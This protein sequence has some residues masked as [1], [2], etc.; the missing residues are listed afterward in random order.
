MLL[1][2]KF[3]ALKWFIWRLKSCHI[4]ISR[5]F[6]SIIKSRLLIKRFSLWSKVCCLFWFCSRRILVRFV[7]WVK[8][9]W[10]RILC[11]CSHLGLGID[12][13]IWLLG[14]SRREG[15]W[16]VSILQISLLS[17]LLCQGLLSPNTCVL[18][19]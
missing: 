8:W 5:T 9:F 13:W 18:R 2:Q 15:F 16:V 17:V 3:L 7:L 12:I 19:C 10:G 4:I 14:S 1:I 11:V 6:I